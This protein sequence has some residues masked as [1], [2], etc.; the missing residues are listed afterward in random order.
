MASRK[1]VLHQ[2]KVDDREVSI[3]FS[4]RRY[5]RG[6]STTIYTWADVLV[7]GAWWSLGDPWPCINPPREQ[8]RREVRRVLSGVETEGRAYYAFSGE[9][10][11]KTTV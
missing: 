3:H 4:R 11:V 9:S 1:L 7:D 10:D 2:L 5:G 8:L 6:E